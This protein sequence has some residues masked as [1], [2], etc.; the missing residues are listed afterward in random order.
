[1]TLPVLTWEPNGTDGDFQCEK[2]TG[3]KGEMYTV[4]VAKLGETFARCQ[5]GQ[6]MWATWASTRKGAKDACEHHVTFF[7]AQAQ[8]VAG[9][10]RAEIDSG[11][12]CPWCSGVRVRAGEC[13]RTCH[14][15]GPECPICQ[16]PRDRAD[17]TVEA[18]PT[19]PAEIA[20]AAHVDAAND[21]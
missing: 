2:A 9:A 21:F 15:T 20:P 11:A 6:T 7:T 18:V 8:D 14:E 5:I 13:C 1:M 19:P 3:P 4:R 12:R 16:G 10:V 17:D